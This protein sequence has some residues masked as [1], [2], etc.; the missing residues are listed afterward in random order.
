MEKTDKEIWVSDS[1][2]AEKL[3]VSLRES[4]SGAEVIIA[5]FSDLELVKEAEK[6]GAQRIFM[7]CSNWKTIP[8]ENLLAYVKKAKIIAEVESAE[9]AKLALETLEKG[10]SGV[11]MPNA[12][13]SELKAVVDYVRGSTEKL[14]LKEAV[15]KTVLKVGIAARSCIDTGELMSIDEGILVG[16]AGSALFLMQAEVSENPH[17]A[18]RPFRVNAGALSLYALLE[19]GKTK[20]LEELKTGDKVLIV[21]KNGG[22]RAA[23]VVRNKI[24]WRPMLLIEAECE[25]RT[26][27]TIAQDAETIRVLTKTG[28]KSVAE[29]KKGDKILVRLSEEKARHFGVPVEERIIEQ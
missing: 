7:K 18:T 20:Y 23:V 21:N 1:K 5:K 17:V 6:K 29:L 11:Y 4:K 26:V 3:G 22:A 25:G 27:K 12:S 13:E 24:E 8:L 14:E 28:S 9:E 2:L 10:A 16:S 19:G 15:I